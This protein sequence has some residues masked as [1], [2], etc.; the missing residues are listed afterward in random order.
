[1]KTLVKV[2]VAGALFLGV[3]YYLGGVQGWDP[4]QQGIDNRAAITPGMAWTKVFDITGDPREYR[5]LK[6]KAAGPGGL[7]E[8]VVP[9]ARNKFRR[10][11]V[12]Q[13]LKEVSLPEGFEV[14][15]RYSGKVAFT[16]TFDLLG[17]VVRV[18]DAVTMRDLLQYDD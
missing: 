3:I 17:N 2:I 16:V 8:M 9:G 15:F 11:R 12:A 5:P 18:G 13:R 10:E 6:K 14:T 4:S 7:L 1:M